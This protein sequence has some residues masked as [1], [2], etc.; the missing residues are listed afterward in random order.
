VARD[1]LKRGTHAERKRLSE[2]LSSNSFG[3]QLP[4]D[5]GLACHEL[6]EQMNELNRSIVRIVE[7]PVGTEVTALNDL[8]TIKDFV[9]APY[10]IWMENCSELQDKHNALIQSLKRPQT[11]NRMRTTVEASF[12]RLPM[13]SWYDEYASSK[14]DVIEI[15]HIPGEVTVNPDVHLQR[16]YTTRK[17][18]AVDKIPALFPVRTLDQVI[19]HDFA[20][21][22][23][24]K[25]L[26]E[27]LNWDLKKDL[28]SQFEQLFW[29]ISTPQAQK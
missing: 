12:P 29:E 5:R 26:A 7:Q 27:S 22:P 10:Q 28:D 8:S 25:L 23:Y 11:L 21:E 2:L 9:L 3:F 4:Q 16:S 6:S 17:D 18:I 15:A 19:V 1:V 13:K 24:K 20:W 14:K